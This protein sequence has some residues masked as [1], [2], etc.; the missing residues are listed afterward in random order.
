M[1]IGII[2]DVHANYEA[3]TAVLA[4]AER[5]AV[6]RIVC[7]GDLVGYSCRPGDTLELLRDARVSSVHGNHDLMAIGSLEPVDCGPNARAAILWTR[8]TLSASHSEYLRAL[9]PFLGIEP[10]AICL[11]SCLGDT[12][13]RLQRRRD[14]RAQ[15]RVL[16]RFDPRLRICFTGHTH[17]PGVVEISD[18]G[19][20]RGELPLRL[21]AD[22]FY[23]VNPGSVGHLRDPAGGATYA[24]YDPDMGTVEFRRVAYDVDAVMAHNTRH[25]IET[26]L[27]GAA[28]PRGRLA[29]LRSRFVRI[30]ARYGGAIA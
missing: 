2:S 10:D 3:L 30:A 6:E 15:L 4:D 28:R 25:A 22:A 24:I 19:H 9:P 8:R 20:V 21:R 12:T 27:K 7:L 18:G 13:T 14:Y 23:F 17:I 29:R 1:R 11:H 26:P 5:H 16:K